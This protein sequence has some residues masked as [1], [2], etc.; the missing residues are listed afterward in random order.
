[1]P[2]NHFVNSFFLLVA[3]L[4][5]GTNNSFAQDVVGENLVLT[6]PDAEITG[7]NSLTIDMQNAFASIR[8]DNGV[9]VEGGL[10]VN[11]G[12][13]TSGVSFGDD[14]TDLSRWTNSKFGENYVTSFNLFENG[15]VRTPFVLHQDSPTIFSI[16]EVGN[17]SF[18][19]AG[20]DSGDSSLAVLRDDGT[21]RFTVEEASTTEE[22]R[23][24]QRLTNNGAS[25]IEMTNTATGRT[26]SLVADFNNQFQIRQSGPRTANFA[27]R[28]DGTFSFNNLGQSLM[29]LNPAGNLR[30]SGV[31]TEGSDR[32][33]KENV[34]AINPTDV[35]AKVTDLP[36]STWNYINDEEDSQHLGPMAQDF[37]AA[38]G[39]GDDDKKIATL[40]TSGVALAAIQGLNKKLEGTN[41][42][43]ETTN[44]QLKLEVKTLQQQNEALNDRMEKLEAM[45][46]TLAS[47]TTPAEE[48]TSVECR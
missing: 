21:A 8:I 22:F 31:L 48:Y 41:E 10:I 13:F 4:V 27:I 30:I 24:L 33:I 47:S 39:L 42:Q 16:N 7:Q 6:D 20:L 28:G 14:D 26:W 43:L 38:F 18:T 29:A 25:K 34:K 46:K 23:S 12:I 19:T 11:D 17:A 5:L 36:L 15:I 9:T 35:L 2:T 44:S 45:V 1:M 32:D 40:D 37:Y 3:T